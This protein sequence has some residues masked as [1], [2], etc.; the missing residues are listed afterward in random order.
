MGETESKCLYMP[1]A[2]FPVQF[3]VPE[4]PAS[5]WHTRPDSC[6]C[7]FPWAS[8]SRRVPS[9][10]HSSAVKTATLGPGLARTPLSVGAR[11]LVRMC[12]AHL[13]HM[14]LCVHA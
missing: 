10:L 9:C 7:G 2:P 4:S 5:A 1:P 3:L 12:R 13:H 11:V 6:P 8:P 14:P